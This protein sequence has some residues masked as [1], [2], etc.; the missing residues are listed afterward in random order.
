M[1]QTLAVKPVRDRYKT[2]MGSSGWAQNAETIDFYDFGMCGAF[3][4]G[5]GECADTSP[6]AARRRYLAAS[7]DGRLQ[8]AERF[9][10]GET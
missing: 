4:R 8:R 9:V 2:T 1:A 5:T 6:A 10:S 7:M 3:R